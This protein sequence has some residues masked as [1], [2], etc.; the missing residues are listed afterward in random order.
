M[1]QL[2]RTQE[3]NALRAKA[4]PHRCNPR[5]HAHI[6]VCVHIDAYTCAR[7]F[8]YRC[9][10]VRVKLHIL[11]RA[12]MMQCPGCTCECVEQSE[13]ECSPSL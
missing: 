6:K 7:M 2:K 1:A 10:C 12:Y 5:Y 13:C 9:V 4:K 11:Y 8:A 3:K